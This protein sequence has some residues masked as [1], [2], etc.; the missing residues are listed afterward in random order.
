MYLTKLK[1]DV[2]AGGN[3][4][5]TVVAPVEAFCIIRYNFY[6]AYPRFE[7][8]FLNL[9]RISYLEF[10]IFSSTPFEGGIIA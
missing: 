2:L 9:F 10:R 1:A 3:L 8:G 4:A 6:D 5:D 7:F